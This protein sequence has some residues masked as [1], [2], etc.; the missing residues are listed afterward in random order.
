TQPLLRLSAIDIS[1]DHPARTMVFI[2]GFGGN[3]RQW[4]YQ[5]Q[6][7]SDDSRCIALDLR[8]FGM[9]DKPADA[10][11]TMSEFVNDIDRALNVLGVTEPF[12]LLGHSFGGAIVA[13][14][15][16]A[17]PERVSKL[18]LLASA[19][20]YNL[21][22]IHKAALRLPTALLNVAQAA[23]L[24]DLFFTTPHIMQTM[25]R[26]TLSGWNGRDL[27]RQ[28]RV[29]TLVIRGNR[30]V[31]FE[32]KYFEE[33]A[34]IIPNAEEVNVGAS[35]HLVMLERRDAVNRAIERFVTETKSR[36]APDG[37][38]EADAQDKL[39]QE[40]PWLGH[41]DEGVPFTIGIPN[42]PIYRFL[43][44]AARRFPLK[45][46]IVFE[47]NRLSYRRLN[48]ESSRFANMLRSAGVQQGEK[49]L[50]L[51]PNLPQTVIAYYG[52]LKMGAVVVF[53]T[54]LSEPNELA[55]QVRESGA[56]AL[57][58]L[59]KL[60][61]VARTV[62]A[63][64]GLKH[65][66]LTNVKDYLPEPQKLA[67]MLTRE[68]KEGHKL[69]QPLEPGLH[70]LS[71]E[72]YKHEPHAPE[73]NVQ[74]DDL[75]LIQFT[76][77]TTAEPKGVML[78]HR[79]LIANTLQTRHWLPSA[80]EGKETFLS[81]LPFSHVYGMTAAMNVPIALAATMI[82]MPSF[83]TEAVLNAIKA[84]R[85]T[86]FPG[87]PTMYMAL[88]NFPGVRKYGIGS[89][90]AC[91]SGSAPLPV[92]VQ[93]AFE[94]LTK[95]KLVEGYGLTEATTATHANPLGGRRRVGSIGI[96]L[97]STEARIVDLASGQT[98][99]SGQVGE[100]AVRGPQVMMGYW[101]EGRSDFITPDGWL[102]TGDMARMEADGFVEI[103]ARKR[104]MILAGA[105][106][107]YP[108]DVEEVLYE[109]PKV[110]EVAVVGVPQATSPGQLV[111][112]FVVLREGSQLSAE[113][114]IALCKRRL[115][116]YAVP[117]EIEFRNELP[118]NFVGKVVRRLLVETE[119]DNAGAGGRVG[120]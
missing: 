24:K 120:R 35:A 103:V 62:K 47:G 108:R 54:P 117:W 50:L 86:I 84:Y 53:T 29:P 21:H 10:Q 14:Y 43:R 59:T 73:V 72:L 96:P 90:K 56:A 49:V 116:E 51:L 88:N 31:V 95:G 97:P 114:L 37:A 66:I 20:E 87:V 17:H 74:P 85:P 67:F 115:E 104:E 98:L 83:S 40:R 12:V 16:L 45:T 7:F 38:L 101:P 8:G 2:H 5:L 30:D 113:E 22:P 91:L 64:T 69:E 102:L 27:F 100:L 110:K 4:K 33:V 70:L 13:E 46:A 25:Y 71:A 81:V 112:A 55:R 36:R 18:V 89:I 32:P 3:A 109:H 106:Q 28:L 15:A 111:K 34:R 92:E 19:V 119:G 80:K 61:D 9:A 6:K 63:Q 60:A 105:Y 57:V 107:V 77:G 23:W 93:E 65:V 79:N 76:S 82:V 68:V 48:R 75:A 94:K 52:A 42:M 41:Y 78:S 1:P 58:T 26:N 118:K 44:S 39:R 11:Y 99:P